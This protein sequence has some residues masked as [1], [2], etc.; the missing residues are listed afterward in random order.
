M[1]IPATQDLICNCLLLEENKDI[2]IETR[3]VQRSSP[4]Y[5]PNSLLVTTW[6]K[7]IW[8]WLIFIY[9][10]QNSF[11]V[12]ELFC[13]NICIVK[14]FI[15]MMPLFHESWMCESSLSQKIL[16]NENWCINNKHVGVCFKNG[17]CNVRWLF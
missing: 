10:C 6:L 9:C 12:C 1:A 8:E 14:Q 16:A 2:L 4:I 17:W 5:P 13:Q 11:K 15:W 3:S 7:F